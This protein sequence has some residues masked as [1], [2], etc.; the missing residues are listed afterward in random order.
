MAR[1]LKTGPYVEESLMKKVQEMNKGNKK[2]GLTCV[3]SATSN[4]DGR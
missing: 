1:S 2:T 4:W 3:P